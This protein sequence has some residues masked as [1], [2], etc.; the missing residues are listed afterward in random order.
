MKWMSGILY[1]V[2]FL[3]SVALIAIGQRNIGPVGLLVMLVGLAG[4]LVRLYL[5]TRKFR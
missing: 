5:Y 2:I 3:V 1:T 4:I